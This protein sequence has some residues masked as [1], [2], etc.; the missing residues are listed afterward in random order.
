MIEHIISG[1][2][3]KE[4][5]DFETKMLAKYREVIGLY[6]PLFD[7]VGCELKLELGWNNPIRKIWSS[8]RIPLRNG[9]ECY[10]YCLVEKGGEE[11]RIKCN[12][13]EADYYPMETAWMISSV[14]RRFH[15]L[16]VSLYKDL[17]DIDTDMNGL[18]TR[19]KYME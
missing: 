11:V 17:D 19:L 10:I 16:K 3:E 9:Y 18:L 12:D 6:T 13:G 7:N 2:R 8:N 1:E 5:C 14:N 15:K 4:I